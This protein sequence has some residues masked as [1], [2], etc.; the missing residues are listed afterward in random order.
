MDHFPL[1]NGTLARLCCLLVPVDGTEVNLVV[2]AIDLLNW[3]K[4]RDAQ[5]RSR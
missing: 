5:D 4:D 2:L 3:S 1:T